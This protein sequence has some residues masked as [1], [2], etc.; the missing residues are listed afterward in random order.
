MSYRVVIAPGVQTALGHLDRAIQ[1]RIASKIDACAHDPIAAL[2]PVLG[3][4][5]GAAH[6]GDWRLIA[7]VEKAEASVLILAL[8]PLRPTVRG[9]P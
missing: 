6:I 3:T 2:V 1:H 7:R 8:R 4:D 9:L 5:L